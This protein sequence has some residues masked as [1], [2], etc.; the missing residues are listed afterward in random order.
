MDVVVEIESPITDKERQ[1]AEIWAELLNVDIKQIGR[2]STFFEL[3]GD[4]ISAIQLVSKCKSIGIEI[5]TNMVFKK[6][7]LKLMAACNQ[8]AEVFEIL[9]LVIPY[10]LY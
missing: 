10:Y 2:A 8:R 7:T 3:G 9:P 1:L 5:D 6:P 4:S